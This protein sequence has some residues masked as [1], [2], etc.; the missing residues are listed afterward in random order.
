MKIKIYLIRI[1]LPLIFFL[2]ILWII[3]LANSADYNYAFFMVGTIPYGDKIAHALLYGMMALSFN[4]ILTKLQAWTI[5]PLPKDF[6]IEAVHLFT[7][8]G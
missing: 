7:R 3:F 8:R 6:M 4:S 1:A 2:F 5:A